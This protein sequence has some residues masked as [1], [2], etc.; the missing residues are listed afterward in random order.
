MSVMFR[1]SIPYTLPAG[2]KPGAGSPIW[3][4]ID[5]LEGVTHQQAISVEQATG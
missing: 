1:K 5:I 4:V 3:K 2:S